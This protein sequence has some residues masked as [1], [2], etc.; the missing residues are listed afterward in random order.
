[1]SAGFTLV[2][3]IVAVFIFSVVMIVAST[4]VVTMLDANRKAQ[5]TKTVMNNLNFA[6]DSMTRA[7]RVGTDYG[8]GSAKT[9]P[10]G[11]TEFSFMDRDG[12]QVT[13]AFSQPRGSEKGSIERDV[14]DGSGFLPVTAP[15]VDIDTFMFYLVGDGAS[16][17]PRVLVI[18]RGTAGKTERTKVAFDLET[19]ITQ[20][21]LERVE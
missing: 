2:E 9:C 3:M 15:D 7:I 1:M 8:C 11:S 13:Y 21:F 6:L 12:R 14:G 5:A 20:R 4:S 10:D 18:I 17:Q 19:L 16:E